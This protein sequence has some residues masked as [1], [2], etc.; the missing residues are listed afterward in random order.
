VFQRTAQDTV[1]GHRR[2]A[3]GESHATGVTQ[4]Y[5][6]AQL[7]TLQAPGKGA[8]REHPGLPGPLAAVENQLG[9]GRGIQHRTAVRRA[10]QAGDTAGGGGAGLAGNIALATKTRLAQADIQIDQT[11]TGD[12]AAGVYGHR[13]LEALW[14][15]AEGVDQTVVDMHV[16]DLIEL[17]GRVDHPGAADGN[18]HAHS[19]PCLGWRWVVC[20]AM[21]MDI[22][23]M[24]TA[25]P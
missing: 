15:V 22:T 21:A 2:Q 23:A 5:Q 8:N 4:G 11:G 16:G 10:A 13:G 19:A 9:H 18:T 3:L 20:P 1:A 25:M 6:L 7:L 12:Q 17:A 24:R 14:G